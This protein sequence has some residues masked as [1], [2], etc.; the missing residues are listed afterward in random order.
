[1]KKPNQN[2]L[3]LESCFLETVS[4]FSPGYSFFCITEFQKLKDLILL[5]V[6]TASVNIITSPAVFFVPG[7]AHPGSVSF[8]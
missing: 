6:S 2:M 7:S 3:R 4:R 8:F 5:L 1:M